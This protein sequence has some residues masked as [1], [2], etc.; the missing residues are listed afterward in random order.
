MTEVSTNSN[1]I[2]SSLRLNSCSILFNI[3]INDLYLWI[4]KTDLLNFAD[5]NTITAAERTIENLISKLEPGSQ[6]AIEWFK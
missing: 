5:D 2:W 1:L 3:F 6:V 4:T